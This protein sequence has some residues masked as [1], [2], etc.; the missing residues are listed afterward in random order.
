MQVRREDVEMQERRFLP[1]LK[2]SLFIHPT[3]TFYGIGCDATNPRLVMRLR[4]LK[5]WQTQPFTVIAPS[6]EWVL[7]NM[8]VP[9]EV[10]NLFPGPVTVIARMKNPDCVCHDVHLGSE[11][12]G[13]RIPNHWIADVVAKLDVPVVSSCANKRAEDLMTSIENADKDLVDASEVVLHEGPKKGRAALFIDYT[14]GTQL[15]TE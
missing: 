15:I 7:E 9:P 2:R 13:V 8:D 14:E 5:R 1:L 3:D 12:L 6:V 11:T 4:L 10:A